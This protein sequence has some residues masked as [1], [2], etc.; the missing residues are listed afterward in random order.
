[1]VVT[2]INQAVYCPWPSRLNDARTQLQ[3]GWIDS[4]IDLGRTIGVQVVHFEPSDDASL[5]DAEMRDIER[6]DRLAQAAAGAIEAYAS[7]APQAVKN[8][9]VVRL[10]AYLL[11]T[12]RAERVRS[13]NG[14]FDFEPIPFNAG[15]AMRYSGVQKMLSP[16]RVNPVGVVEAE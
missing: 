8:E 7:E 5:S 3:Q 14:V 12:Q 9:G 13:I 1:M 4:V 15:V 11:D 2:L 6:V 10:A 16:Y